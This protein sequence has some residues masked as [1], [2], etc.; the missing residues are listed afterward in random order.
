MKTLAAILTQLKQPLELD[1]VEI[2]K[3]EYGQVLVELKTSRICGSQIGEIDG[4]KGE[5]RW[6]PHL[7]GHEA[8]GIV[9]EVGPEVTTVKPDDHV[10]A[11]W[12]PGAGVQSRP[13]KYKRGSQTINAGWITTFNH[14][15]VLSENRV[16]RIPEDLDLE[17]A[18]LLADTL[19]TGFGI[20]N[21]DAKA[22]IGESL[23]IFGAGGIGLGAIL[24][25]KLAG[26]HPIVAVDLFPHKLEMAKQ[27]GATHTLDGSS[28]DITEQVQAIV[29]KRGADI[30]L[31]GTG[32]PSIIERCYSLT[33]PKGRCV[34]YGVMSH[35][36]A[37]SIHTLPLHF[38][39]LLTGSEGGGSQPH[40]DIPRL[41]RMIQNDQFDPKPMISHRGSLQ[42][43]DE[44]ISKMRKGEVIH[45][46]MNY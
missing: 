16:T 30:T 9:R 8:G 21:R 41:V 11:H 5:D 31:D 10:V 26:L 45:A 42:E 4:V 27:F 18:A 3:L 39:K 34:L 12:R 19:T 7:L 46:V 2:P 15:A 6:L 40:E 36:K 33:Q 14:W 23:V 24:G 38:G 28:Q 20:I 17:I 37:V 32:N 43:V 25:A 22:R 1:E 35:D 44:L 13:P 29:G